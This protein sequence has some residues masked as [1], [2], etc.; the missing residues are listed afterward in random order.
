MKDVC[1]R[2]ATAADS[3]AV[4]KLCA[5]L[6]PN[7]YMLQAW[8][9]WMGS[10]GDLQLVAEWRGHFAGC[11]RAGIIG[12]S[13]AFLQGLRVDP[14]RQ[15]L[16]IG[17]EL[18][19]A[20]DERLRRRGVAAQRAVTS[21]TNAPALALL[22]SLGWRRVRSVNR[23][24]HPGIVE[25]DL[26]TALLPSARPPA[27][28]ADRLPLVSRRGVAFFGRIYS[29]GRSSW[30][31]EEWRKGRIVGDGGGWVAID[32][33]ADG[34][35]WIHTLVGEG[36]AAHTLLGGLLN[37]EGR[38]PRREVILEAEADPVFQTILDELGFAARGPAERYAVMEKA[39]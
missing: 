25:S 1:I 24:R 19:T 22:A 7:D 3:A 2:D 6:D 13:E 39:P 15:R 20:L 10:P 33:L 32:P 31:A 36:A 14:E 27:I 23:R 21:S 29:S 17:R 35:V 8:N 28:D 34:P 16:G 9:L 37:G 11:V 26:G 4:L 18:M 38:G 5:Q 12:G 30:I